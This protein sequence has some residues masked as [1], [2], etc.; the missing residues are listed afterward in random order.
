MKD[1]YRVHTVKQ[2]DIDF[3]DCFRLWDED[4][5]QTYDEAIEAFDRCSSS[6]PSIHSNANMD[7]YSDA[8][9]LT[10]FLTFADTTYRKAG[11]EY[12]IDLGI[13]VI[14]RKV[15]ERELNFSELKEQARREINEAFGIPPQFLG[16]RGNE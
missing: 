6:Y 1:T 10:V 16:S 7:R 13:G 11:E 8:L 9:P 14:A 2:K 15:V 3:G 4:T 5:F 12:C